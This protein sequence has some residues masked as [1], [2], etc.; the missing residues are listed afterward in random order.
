ML[1]SHCPLKASLEK[2]FEASLHS[3][4]CGNGRRPGYYWVLAF[5]IFV[6]SFT[7]SLLLYLYLGKPKI[8]QKFAGGRCL[9]SLL[10]QTLVNSACCPRYKY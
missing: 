5:K 2:F 1:S 3:S 10:S 7:A 6:S 8:S 9:F 4:S